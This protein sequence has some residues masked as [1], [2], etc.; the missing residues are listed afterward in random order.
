MNNKIKC[1]EAATQAII[2]SIVTIAYEL[3]SITFPTMPGMLSII[4]SLLK[5]VVIIIILRKI[6]A[7][8][9]IKRAPLSYG[10]SFRYGMAV[11]FFSSII[12]ASVATLLYTV[13]FPDISEQLVENTFMILEEANVGTM[14]DYDELSSGI[15]KY[16]LFSKFFSC[17]ISGL[18]ISAI[19][20]TGT[21]TLNSDNPF[22]QGE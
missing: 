4:L 19:L 6:M 17:M 21:K 13:V 14:L 10:G 5:L 1:S 18:I 15:F 9:A 8:D 11:C 16:I 12:C 7:K 2:L 22:E 3:I 20:A